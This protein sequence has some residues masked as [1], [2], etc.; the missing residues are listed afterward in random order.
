[1]AESKVISMRMPVTPTYK[2]DSLPILMS[3]HGVCNVCCR[4][5]LIFLSKV[6]F[7]RVADEQKELSLPGQL[8]FARSISHER[9]K[10]KWLLNCELSWLR[11][12]SCLRSLSVYPSKIW[13]PRA[14][15]SRFNGKLRQFSAAVA[16]IGPLDFSELYY[17]SRWALDKICDILHFSI[18]VHTG[19]LAKYHFWP[20]ATQKRRIGEQLNCFWNLC[21]AKNK[22]KL[23]FDGKSRGLLLARAALNR[24]YVRLDKGWIC[25][26]LYLGFA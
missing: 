12:T 21:P 3:Y 23:F 9:L 8:T 11:S 6:A 18:A 26:D 22:R 2:R 1:M 16:K 20:V 25:L 13:Q 15:T 7:G 24:F 10:I 17:C 4:L 14:R 19:G 5:F